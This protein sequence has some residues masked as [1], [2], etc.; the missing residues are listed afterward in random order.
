MR[1]T[2]ALILFILIPVLVNA[3][4]EPLN[5][6]EEFTEKLKQAS[7]SNNSIKADFV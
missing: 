3:Q 7:I 5:N 1:L 4:Q 6:P 2:I